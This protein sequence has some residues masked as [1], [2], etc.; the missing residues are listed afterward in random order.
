MAAEAVKTLNLTVKRIPC[1]DATLYPI[2]PASC[3][4]NVAKRFAHVE[5]TWLGDG[6]SAHGIGSQAVPLALWRVVVK[7][8]LTYAHHLRIHRQEHG[9]QN[10]ASG[11]CLFWLKG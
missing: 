1:I 6:F 8:S 9:L 3:P 2:A 4:M 7:A 11:D 10:A 5:E